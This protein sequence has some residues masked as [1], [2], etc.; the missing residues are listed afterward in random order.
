MDIIGHLNDG[1]ELHLYGLTIPLPHLPTFDMSVTRVVV[2]MW[3]A[4]F[5]TWWLITRV[6]KGDPK[7]PQGW[8]N[9]IEAVLLFIR[10]DICKPYLGKEGMRFF[11]FIATLFFF[12][13]AMNWLGLIPQ[14]FGQTA[15]GHI[16]VTGALAAMAFVLIQFVGIRKYGFFRHCRNFIPPVP[17]PL[18]IIMIPV[19]IM[20][21]LVKPFALCVRL[22]AN[23][24]AG[25]CMLLALI[26]MTIMAGSLP[27]YGSLPIAAS[28][29]LGL[30]FIFLLEMLVGLIQAYVFVFLTAVFMGQTLYAEH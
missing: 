21:I 12:I 4:A 26:G 14:P 13:L 5:I 7:H 19:E 30:I 29:E 6:A 8:H 3:V 1:G 18:L 10:E 16:M 15:T 17:A 2:M 23:M 28:I 24:T 25:H 27:A 20:G 9:A 11:P 22:F